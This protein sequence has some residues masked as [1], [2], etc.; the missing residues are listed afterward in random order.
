MWA[1][2][3]CSII[4]ELET[5]G[6]GFIS[7]RPRSSTVCTPLLLLA[8]SPRQRLFEVVELMGVP[9]APF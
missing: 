5:T 3:T 8:R 2:G 7:L 9:E 4:L 6:R 1:E